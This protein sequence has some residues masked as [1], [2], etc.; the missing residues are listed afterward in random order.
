MRFP[1]LGQVLRTECPKNDYLISG[2]LI[3]AILPSAC[4]NLDVPET[5]SPVSRARGAVAVPLS[6]AKTKASNA[7]E[8]PATPALAS[9]PTAIAPSSGPVESS[10]T[11]APSTGIAHAPCPPEM[12]QVGR[13]CVDR[14]EAYLVEV[15]ASGVE[16]P[17]PPYRRPESGGTYRA[18][19]K[20]GEFPQ[21]YINKNESQAACTQA[22]KRLCTLAEWYRAC[23]G[24]ARS[25]YP[26]G[27][28]FDKKKC[29]ISKAHLLS[30][31]YGTDSHAWKYD[32]HFNDPKLD[33]E[34]GFLSRGGE[35]TECVSSYGVYDLVGNLHEWVADSID[36][37]LPRKIPLREDIEAKIGRNRGH[38]IFMGGFFS[39]TAEHGH[40]CQFLTPG[41][42][43]KYHDYSTGFRC[44]KDAAPA[45]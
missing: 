5:A 12:A 16:H 27:P 45:P 14:W 38:G 22:G 4:R 25:I 39:T 8:A 44:C 1:W 26:Y 31:M 23:T 37:D 41:H 36:F 11:S 20:A 40:G 2:L 28:N 43:G 3:L 29:N 7:F 15:D 42:E 6:G 10:P 32:Q 19:S 17:H 21:A 24:E 33:Q 13:S 35:Y 18:Q 9:S 30:R 34:P